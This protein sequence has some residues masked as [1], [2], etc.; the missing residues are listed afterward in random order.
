M[1]LFMKKR[2]I[3]ILG[4]KTDM[5]LLIACVLL[6]AFIIIN[7]SCSCINKPCTKCKDKGG[8]GCSCGNSPCTCGKGHPSLEKS[9]MPPPSNIIGADQNTYSDLASV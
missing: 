2:T 3:T 9:K 6:T 7:T 4:R 5:H 1:F 8:G